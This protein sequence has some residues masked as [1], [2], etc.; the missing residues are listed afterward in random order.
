MTKYRLALKQTFCFDNEESCFDALVSA[1]DEAQKEGFRIVRITKNQYILQKG[2][3][4]RN[5]LITRKFE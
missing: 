2:G 5:I 1:I 4:Y 3:E